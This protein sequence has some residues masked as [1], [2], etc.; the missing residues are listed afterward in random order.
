MIRSHPLLDA[1]RR[2]ARRGSDVVIYRH[3]IRRNYILAETNGQVTREIAV[4]PNW[5]RLT[6]LQMRGL[7]R[8]L[9]PLPN[10]RRAREKLITQQVDARRERVR[11]SGRFSRE[12]MFNVQKRTK[13][14]KKDHPSINWSKI[15]GEGI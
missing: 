11:N 1:L 13:G 6:Q 10:T 5:P 14:V 9:R 12:M 3:G 8:Q 7:V 2:E 4:L 15:P